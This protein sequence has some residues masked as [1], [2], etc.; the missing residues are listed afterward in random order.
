MYFGKQTGIFL[1]AAA[2]LISL[3]LG[4][5]GAFFDERAEPLAFVLDLVLEPADLVLAVFLAVK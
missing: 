4:G 2:L 3:F 1:A 5:S